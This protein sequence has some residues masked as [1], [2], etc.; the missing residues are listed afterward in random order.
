MSVAAVLYFFPVRGGGWL[1]ENTFLLL[2]FLK[3][4]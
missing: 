2:F 4:Y 1:T 3:E